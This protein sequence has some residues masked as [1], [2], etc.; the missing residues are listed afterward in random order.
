MRAI[1]ICSGIIFMLQDVNILELGLIGVF[2]EPVATGRET[3]RL[4]GRGWNK[5]LTR[6][7]NAS[8]VFSFHAKRS[9]CLVFWAQ[10]ITICWCLSDTFH[11][12]EIIYAWCYAAKGK[13]YCGDSLVTIL[14][15]MLA[16][17]LWLVCKELLF[18]FVVPCPSHVA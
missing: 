10:T 14:P 11:S 2:P 5:G 13:T 9:A 3:S 17:L 6:I 4:F 7:L 1:A 18:A 8:D 12:T 16:P 15:L